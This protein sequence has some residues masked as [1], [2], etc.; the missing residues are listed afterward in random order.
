MGA[1][2]A[3]AG[4]TLFR[5]PLAFI[6]GAVMGRSD[7]SHGV[8]VPLIALWFLWRRRGE[9]AG[10]PP[11]T[12]RI[13]LALALPALTA[14]LLTRSP[15]L[16]GLAFLVLA[17]GLILLSC[18]RRWLSVCAFPVFYLLAAV[19]L[20]DALYQQLA[21]GVRWITTAGSLELL[22]LMGIPFYRQGW[23]VQLANAN[24]H[25]AIGC[26]GIRYLLSFL[27]FGIAYAW[28]TRGRT[29]ARL[30]VVALTLPIGLGAGVLRLLSIYLMTALFGPRMAEP[31]PHVLISWA[32]FALVMFACLILDRQG[33]SGKKPQGSRG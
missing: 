13:G 24:L 22:S 14:P 31:G 17:A 12:D 10:L 19:P 16:L 5:E 3:L 29:P 23:D 32:V 7:S 9:L 1:L 20:P 28:L 33:G 11:V 21:E 6:A 15:Q 18:G 4:L 26:S 27:V 25:V 30:A 8:F 2:L